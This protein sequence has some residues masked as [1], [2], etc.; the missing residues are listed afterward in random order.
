MI[1]PRREFPDKVIGQIVHRALN[2]RGMP[3]CEKCG[4]VLGKKKY[5]IDHRIPE[6]L[7]VDKTKPLTAADGW[8]LGKDCCHDPKTAIDKGVIAKAKRRERNSLG[9][10]R[11]RGWPSK[12][13]KKLSGE[14]VLR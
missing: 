9:L 10:P 13:R 5:E 2:G 1:Q 3:V 11:K 4:L 6:A 14:V 7:I 8:L 12:Y